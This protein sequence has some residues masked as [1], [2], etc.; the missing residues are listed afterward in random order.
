MPPV[1][2]AFAAAALVYGLSAHAQVGAPPARPLPVTIPFE[3]VSRHIMVRASVNNS[4]PLPFVLDTGA[5]AALVRMETATSLNLTLDQPIRSGGAGPATQV[6]RTIK[7]AQWSLAGLAGFSQPVAF[8]LPFDEVPSALGHEV[9]GIIGGQFIKQFV[10]EL[11]YQARTITLHNADTFTYTGSGDVLPL[12]F[13]NNTHPVVTAVVT[14]LD[15]RSFER[16]FVVDLGS[17]GALLLHVPF[18]AEQHL[19]DSQPSTIRAIGAAGA[20]GKTVGRIGRVA[21]LRLGRFTLNNPIT[22]FSQDTGGAFTNAALAGN[23]GAQLAMRFRLF[24]DYGRRRL[25]LEPAAGFDAPFDRASSGVALRAQGRDFST[26]RVFEVLENSPATD[27]GLQVDDV[28]ET[29]D[30]QSAA[31]LTLTRISELFE[32]PASYALTVKRGTQTLRMT[33][34]PRKMI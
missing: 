20:G 19:L 29:I 1:R 31:G 10:L 12:E 4:S 28:I 26:I 8:A 33:L 30:G 16:K 3:L 21:S 5:D 32:K 18:V 7:G 22:M 27:A 6:G 17:G 13:S 11:D 14:T 15:G 2:I 25:I 23:I 34:T 9:D 24:L